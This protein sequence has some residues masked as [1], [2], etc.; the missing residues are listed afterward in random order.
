MNA[1]K[2][3]LYSASN[4]AAK[5]K[6]IYSTTH[7]SSEGT[8]SVRIYANSDKQSFRSVFAEFC[9]TDKSDPQ[10]DYSADAYV[11]ISP[12][13]PNYNVACEAAYKLKL[14]QQKATLR[15]LETKLGLAH[16]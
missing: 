16:S 7:Q 3:G 9:I 8:L 5:T 10:S 1:I 13:N 11:E 2:F 14:K 12:S 15:R 4:G 6:V